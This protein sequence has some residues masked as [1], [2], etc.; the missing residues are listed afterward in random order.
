MEQLHHAIGFLGKHGISFIFHTTRY[1]ATHLT[2]LQ[3]T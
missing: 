3:E 2:N 1:L